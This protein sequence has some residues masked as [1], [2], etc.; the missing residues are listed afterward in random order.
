MS[1]F[2]QTRNNSARIDNKPRVERSAIGL[3]I[4]RDFE[5]ARATIDDISSCRTYSDWLD[6]REGLQIGLSMAGVDVPMVRV[7]LSSFLQWR[8]L[9]GSSSGERALDAFAALALTV[10]N[11]CTLRVFAIVTELDLAAR[12]LDVHVLDGPRDYPSWARH[13][14]AMRAKAIAAGLQVQELPVRIKDFSEW[15][16]CLGQD[17]SEP[18]LDRY[19]QLLLEHL[20]SDVAG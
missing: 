3:L 20:T 2:D 10:R 6:L 13:R 5:G 7:A 9:T 1:I 18:A 17:P 14:R 4:E 8:D 11:S 16:A 19:A 15:C 12:A